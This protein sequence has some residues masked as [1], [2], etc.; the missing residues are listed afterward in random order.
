MDQTKA[1]NET[2]KYAHNWQWQLQNKPK[3]R[4]QTNNQ[5]AREFTLYELTNMYSD[6]TD[7]S[8]SNT[9]SQRKRLS[10]R[11]VERQTPQINYIFYEWNV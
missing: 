1:E 6:N 3:R 11:D 2:L 4:R 10:K 7:S 9:L 5:Y 8:V